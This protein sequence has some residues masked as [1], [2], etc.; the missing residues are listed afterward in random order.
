MLNLDKTRKALRRVF[1]TYETAAPEDQPITLD[2]CEKMIKRLEGRLVRKARM[3]EAISK[4]NTKLIAE[5]LTQGFEG[6]VREIKINRQDV[7][8]VRENI[9]ESL[10][11]LND[12]VTLLSDGSLEDKMLQ[13]RAVKCAAP[14][15]SV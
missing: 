13:V 6:F 2:E 4:Q 9:C 10:I 15:R 14:G 3:M 12:R 7:L 8:A 1:P 11:V 5:S